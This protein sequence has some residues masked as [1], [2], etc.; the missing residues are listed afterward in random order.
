MVKRTAHCFL[1]FAKL[2]KFVMHYEAIMDWQNGFVVRLNKLQHHLLSNTAIY[3]L[4]MVS[5]TLEEHVLNRSVCL[6]DSV[7]QRWPIYINFRQVYSCW[8]L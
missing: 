7:S 1:K 4:K 3:V 5:M 2:S 8:F 6:Q